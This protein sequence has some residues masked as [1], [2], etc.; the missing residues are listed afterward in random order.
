MTL[1]LGGSASP[2]GWSV[3]FL[4]LPFDAAMDGV[5]RAHAGNPTE[6]SAPR[7]F[8]DALID[9]TPF[10]APWT[11]EVLAPCGS[12]TTYLNNGLHGGDP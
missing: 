1:L 3:Q 7:P 9:L 5:R 6:V 11:R 4:E 10:Q 2:I 12:W 8:P